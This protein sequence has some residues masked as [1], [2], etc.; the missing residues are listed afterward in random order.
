MD[1]RQ[2]LALAGE[3]HR[4]GDEIE[5]ATQALRQLEAERDRLLDE[6]RTFYTGRSEPTLPAPAPS[7]ALA[8]IREERTSVLRGVTPV[9]TLTGTIR[10]FLFANTKIPV[11]ISEFMRVQGLTADQRSAVKN[12]FAGVHRPDLGF[13]RVGGGEYVHDESL[14]IEE[15]QRGVEARKP[16]STRLRE[17]FMANPE[18]VVNPAAAV[19]ILGWDKS[20]RAR[21]N[22]M[23]VQL[24]DSEFLARVA[25]GQYQLREGKK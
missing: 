15:W 16:A 14:T 24:Y 3:I 21:V 11:S 10:K 2:A 7:G 5:G 13:F 12:A 18:A 17:W 23:L 25:R 22:A 1:E 4:L 6:W 19:E 8:P 20:Q 9:R